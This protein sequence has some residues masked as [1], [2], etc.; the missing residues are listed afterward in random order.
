MHKSKEREERGMQRET[1]SQERK[2]VK[3]MQHEN[4]QSQ[5]LGAYIL[6]LFIA[7]FSQI[8]FL[9]HTGSNFA[10]NVMFRIMTTIVWSGKQHMH[11]HTHIGNG[12]YK[13]EN[14]ISAFSSF[15]HISSCKKHPATPIPM[16]QTSVYISLLIKN[17][18]QKSALWQKKFC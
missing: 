12:F 1:K 13:P 14:A 7:K 6:R 8:C 4:R 10:Q 2:C 11:V 9:R 5:W 17:C 15:S 16:G 3:R 18:G